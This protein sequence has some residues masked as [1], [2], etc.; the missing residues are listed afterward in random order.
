MRASEDTL[1]KLIHT[2]HST[3]RRKRLWSTTAKFCHGC[4][5]SLP[6]TSTHL[7]LTIT[8]TL[9]TNRSQTIQEL[10]FWTT[11]VV[12]PPTMSD[13]KSSYRGNRSIS[14]FSSKDRLH[15]GDPVRYV[16]CMSLR[17]V[18]EWVEQRPYNGVSKKIIV[19]EPPICTCWLSPHPKYLDN[20]RHKQV[21][22]FILTVSFHRR[23]TTVYLQA[24]YIL[25]VDARRKC[26]A[27]QIYTINLGLQWPYMSDRKMWPLNYYI[28]DL[29]VVL[30]SDMSVRKPLSPKENWLHHL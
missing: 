15:G 22:P 18:I 26:V 21:E 11:T 9:R 19:W 3:R 20:D 1:S 8:I 7:I 4:Q 12:R 16:F 10:S 30:Y 6:I 17:H 13:T 25:T 28:G 2:E 29:D 5:I 27:K 14:N 23:T 24:A